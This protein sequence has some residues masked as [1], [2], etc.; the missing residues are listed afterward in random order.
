M[1]DNRITSAEDLRSL[2]VFRCLEAPDWGRYA[3]VD[4]NGELYMFRESISMT[5]MD[6][7]EVDSIWVPT[8]EI[9]DGSF[10]NSLY[11]LIYTFKQDVSK[12]WKESM[13]ELA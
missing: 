3:A 9:N 5:A 6:E 4:A 13:V 10:S 7:E 1:R 12:L 2:I 8:A 11:V